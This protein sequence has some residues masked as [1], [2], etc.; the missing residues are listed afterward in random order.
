EAPPGPWLRWN[1]IGFIDSGW[2]NKLTIEVDTFRTQLRLTGITFVEDPDHPESWL[3]DLRLQWW[4]AVAESWRNGPLLLSD[5]A[6]HSHKLE[7]PIEAARFRLVSTGGA[8]RPVGNLRLGELVFHGE[9]LGSSHPDAVA[10]KAV[11]VLFDEKETDL[12]SL[13]SPGRPFGFRY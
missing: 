8:T 3:R 5:A 4:D 13:K 12:T 9:I 7:A 6:V 1:E 2:K 10:R 11:A